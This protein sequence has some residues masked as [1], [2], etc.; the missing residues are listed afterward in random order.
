MKSRL[1]NPLVELVLLLVFMGIIVTNTSFA[2]KKEKRKYPRGCENLGLT[3]KDDLLIISPNNESYKQGVIL[4]HNTSSR[5][6]EIE[7]FN[8]K[9][10]K[11][12]KW[13]NSIKAKRWSS[14]AADKLMHFR[15]KKVTKKGSDAVACSEVLDGCQYPRAKIPL[16]MNG[17]YLI[18]NDTYSRNSVVRKTIR[19][20]ILLR[21]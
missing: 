16:H 11:H 20:G 17:T 3:Y 12:G 4:I 14:F 10:P 6:L 7:Y 2:A 18:T 9:H 1:A 21:W 15:C 5:N 13:K 8:P 19:S